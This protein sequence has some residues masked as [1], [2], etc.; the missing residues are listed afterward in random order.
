MPLQKVTNSDLEINKKSNHS[1][2]IRFK[3]IFCVIKTG[4]Q[5]YA[6]DRANDSQRNKKL[7]GSFDAKF[8]LFHI[9]H[10]LQSFC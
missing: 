10:D 1:R 8:S 9:F 4:A 3:P 7:H 5:K 2:V 6:N